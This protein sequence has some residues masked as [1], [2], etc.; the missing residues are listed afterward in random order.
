[1]HHT[2]LVQDI[3]ILLLAAGIAGVICR[4]VGLSVI[5]GYLLAG[6]LIGPNTPIEM[7]TSEKTIEELA[8]VGLV[9][10]MFSIGL[11]LS[12]TKLAKMGLATI[13]AT[14]LGAAFMF[15]FTLLLGEA[16]DWSYKQSLCVAAMLMVSSSAVISKIMEEMHLTHNKTAQMALA[17]TIVEDIVA[18]VMLAMLA[19]MG[20]DAAG[21]GVVAEESKGVGGVFLQ[22]SSYV[23]LILGLCLLFLPKMLRRLDMSGDTELRTVV[24]AGL[25]LLLAL[26]AEKAGF[27]IALGAFLFGAIVAELPQKEVLEKSFDSVRS[28]F[29]SVFFVSIGMM[30]KP[31]D[32]LTHWHLI[33]ILVAFALFVRPIACGFALMLVGVDPHQARRGGMLLTPLGEFTFIIAMAAISV[34]VFEAHFYPVAIALSICTVLATPILNRFAEPIIDTIEKFEPKWM[35]RAMLA[36]HDWLRQLKNRPAKGSLGVLLR[37]RLLQIVAELLLVTGM[38][39]FSQLLLGAVEK[40]LLPSTENP[41]GV[42]PWLTESVL[43]G[44]FWV[45]MVVIVLVP[46]VA[47]WRNI[48]AVSL[49]LAEQWESRFLPRSLLA[50]G[51]KALSAIGLG[52][53]IY[54]ILP[55]EVKAFSLWARIGILIGI[56]VVIVVFSRRLILWHS[57][58]RSS[59]EEVLSNSSSPVEERAEAR[60][61]LDRGLG[62]WDI[63]LEDCV[64]P[65]GT[66][67][68]G[69]NLHSLAI[70]ARFGIS[71]V[72]IERNG[73]SILSPNPEMQIFPG[74]RLLLLGQSER[75]AEA[76]DF[77]MEK[78][79]E[80]LPDETFEHAILETC[81][82]EQSP[83]S[84]KSF[85]ELGVGQKTGVRIVGIERVGNRIINPSGNE[86]L[87][88][89]DSLL[90]V[91]TIGQI[92]RFVGWLSGR[93]EV[94]SAEDDQRG[95]R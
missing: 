27:N 16:M 31:E 46:L 7:I 77:L 20:G 95:L 51:V 3:G 67:F 43:H 70:P 55:D 44:V 10:V 28:L 90:L 74:D 92:R 9:F 1:M 29:N 21:A 62:A 89:G 24:I 50:Q 33:L 75:I 83:R 79:D 40:H 4:K 61:N 69:K 17:I 66:A 15:S 12:L 45:L 23:V 2:A 73:H 78:R 91:G 22:I 42:F 87:Q 93:S 37:P 35:T 54:P 65:D 36:Y 5:V 39:V 53:W 94:L 72:E 26:C 41:E 47:L 80:S 68:A 25:L 13:M 82:V 76:R 86:I 34:G 14:L 63:H 81:R 64:I 71:V 52:F 56:A 48:G 57:A 19:T 18:V 88:E 60:A 85:A 11:H 58:W 32:L 6:V 38:L 30:A 49:I 8:Q 84:G 59:V